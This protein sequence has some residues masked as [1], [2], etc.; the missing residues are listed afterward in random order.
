MSRLW[1]IERALLDAEMTYHR[2]VLDK[3]IDWDFHDR[4]IAEADKAGDAIPPCLH[5]WVMEVAPD[6][7]RKGVGKALMEWGKKLAKDEGLPFV[8]ESNL[9]A[10][11]FYEK[12]DMKRV[13]DLKL[14]N[15]EG[16]EEFRVPCYAWEAED[17]LLLEECGEGRWR[18]RHLKT[19]P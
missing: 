4:F 1:G 15:R 11:R 16:K 2:Y 8:L 9:E 19:S 3:I 5:L 10:T 18:W 7:Q 6:A 14:A 17:G 13:E 12:L